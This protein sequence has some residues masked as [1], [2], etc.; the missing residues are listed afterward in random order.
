MNTLL[1]E[2][3][4][5]KNYLEDN[6]IYSYSEIKSTDANFKAVIKSD[7]IDNIKH[8]FTDA[9]RVK[10][11]Y[12]YSYEDIKNTFS[13]YLDKN[14]LKEKIIYIKLTKKNNPDM[15][16]KHNILMQRNQ[17]R[18]DYFKNSMTYKKEESITEYKR[19]IIKF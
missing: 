6:G 2:I 1:T 13:V 9:N 7:N 12:K 11:C 18:N 4:C 10:K 3:N 8:L 17:I 15:R 5:F 19:I 16:Y 14:K